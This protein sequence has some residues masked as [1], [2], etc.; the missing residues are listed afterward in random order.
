MLRD[1]CQTSFLNPIYTEKYFNKVYKSIF[2]LGKQAF[3]KQSSGKA[4]KHSR[5]TSLNYKLCQL[6]SS[7]IK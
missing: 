5:I 7:L 6:P 1:T 4:T 3:T 2:E